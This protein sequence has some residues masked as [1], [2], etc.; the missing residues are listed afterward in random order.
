MGVV[1]VTPD[2]FSDGGLYLD[3]EAAIAH[4]RELAAQGAD[5]GAFNRKLAL[6]STAGAVV[7]VH[8]RKAGYIS[9]CDARIIG[10][11]IRD[12]GGGRKT[13][14][15]VIHYDV[16]IDNLVKPG[17]RVEKYGLLC[18]IHAA[19][20]KQAR[21]AARHVKTAIHIVSHQVPPSHLIH[22]LISSDLNISQFAPKF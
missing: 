7:T 6:D 14:E 9:Q 20:L 3:P 12:L 18:R 21:T 10:E 15:S 19:N 11:V 22:E 2:S 17:E 1:N 5:L 4:G 8:A 16:G 13:K